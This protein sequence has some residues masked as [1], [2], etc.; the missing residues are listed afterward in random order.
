M[1]TLNPKKPRFVSLQSFHEDMEFHPQ[2]PDRTS[3]R[4]GKHG[5]EYLEW[6][7]RLAMLK[8]C[9]MQPKGIPGATQWKPYKPE[10]KVPK[11]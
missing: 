3:Y 9:N 11:I 2:N 7:T 4:A 10:Q 8:A 6:P 5:I 1:S